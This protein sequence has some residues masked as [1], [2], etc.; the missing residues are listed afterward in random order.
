MARKR[1]Y[2]VMKQTAY[3]PETEAYDEAQKKKAALK[4]N[5]V[6]ILHPFFL[7]C[8]MGALLW[9]LIDYPG[10]HEILENCNK[11]ETKAETWNPNN[12]TWNIE[13]EEKAWFPYKQWA[14]AVNNVD[15]LEIYYDRRN[16]SAYNEN[17]IDHVVYETYNSA[18]INAAKAVMQPAMNQAYDQWKLKYEGFRDCANLYVEHGDFSMTKTRVLGFVILYSVIFLIS[19]IVRE[20]FLHYF[21]KKEFTAA[22]WK[23]VSHNNIFFIGLSIFVSLLFLGYLILLPYRR[24]E[25][26]LGILSRHWAV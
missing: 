5:L 2:I 9:P 24:R 11:A 15:R 18:D 7:L 22:E 20:I 21:V 6:N 16:E 26:L 13:E 19:L 8:L 17:L 1:E 10:R 25:Y 3:F 23:K 4:Y 12:E 14:K